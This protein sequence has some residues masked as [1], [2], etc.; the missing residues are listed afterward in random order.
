MELLEWGALTF[1]AVVTQ[2]SLSLG[3]NS[4]NNLI[5]TPCLRYVDGFHVVF[6]GSRHVTVHRGTT[7]HFHFP[8]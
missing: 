3:I 2:H 1:L 4:I 5:L 7:Q 8:Y 6:Q